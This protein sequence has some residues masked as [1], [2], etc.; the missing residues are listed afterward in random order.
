[1]IQ[2]ARGTDT[3]SPSAQAS[4]SSGRADAERAL[5]LERAREDVARAQEQVARR[6]LDTLEAEERVASCNASEAARG[7]RRSNAS[8][9]LNVRPTPLGSGE[10]PTPSHSHF[11]TES[12]WQRL[13]QERLDGLRPADVDLESGAAAVGGLSTETPCQASLELMDRGAALFVAQATERLQELLSARG[14]VFQ[15]LSLIHI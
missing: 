4:S 6:R 13:A 7:A 5:E 15:G 14:E 8:V 3:S 11:H 10:Q 12:E 9:H 2:S 1:M